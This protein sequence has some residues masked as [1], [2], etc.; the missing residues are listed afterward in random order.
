MNH[1]LRLAAK[2]I[3]G[4][5]AY[6]F[7]Y[8]ATPDM[9]FDVSLLCEVGQPF[10]PGFKRMIQKRELDLVVVEIGERPWLITVPRAQA[11]EGNN[12]F[13]CPECNAQYLT[14]RFYWREKCSNCG[15][16]YDE[17]KHQNQ[18]K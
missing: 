17:C 11:E 3:A 2:K 6:F 13:H 9:G 7:R 15:F 18:T 10:I 14:S 12:W 4:Y 8:D 5:T 16:A 1:N